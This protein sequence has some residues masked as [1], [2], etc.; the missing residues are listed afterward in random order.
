MKI[1]YSGPIAASVRCM[2][3]YILRYFYI[4]IL[5]FTTVAYSHIQSAF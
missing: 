1:L 5:F 3:F 2:L 4:Y